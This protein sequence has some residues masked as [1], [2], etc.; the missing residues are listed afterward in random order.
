[1]PDEPTQLQMGYVSERSLS[2]KRLGFDPSNMRLDV[3]AS[4]GLEEI[5]VGQETTSTGVV[6]FD[7]GGRT[8]GYPLHIVFCIDK[9][10]SMNNGLE[11]SGLTGIANQILGGGSDTTKMDV[12]KEGL[13]KAL[14][15]LSSNDTFAVVGFNSNATEVVNPANGND[16][17]LAKSNIGSLSASNGTNISGG[18][19]R[20]RR[21]LQGMP[22]EEAVELIVLISDGKGRTPSDRQLQQMYSDAGITIQAAGVGNDYDREELLSVSQQ[23]QGELEHIDSA[24]GLKQFFA[25]EVSNARN[26]VALDA[27]LELKPSTMITI[28]EVYY[29]YAEQTSTV[30]PEWRGRAVALDLGD[31][32]HENPP[33]VTLEMDV[34][35][36]QSDAELEAPLVTAMLQTNED[37][38]SDEMT[39][40]VDPGI[41]IEK[42]DEDGESSAPAPSPEFILKKVSTLA[43]KGQTSK[44]RRY[45]EE[46]EDNLSPAKYSE[47]KS[48]ID[49]DDLSGLSKL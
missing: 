27:E 13:K 4:T 49:D 17:S 43:Q 44:A 42:V 23:T 28:N 8:R 33:E 15:Q 41:G 47:A 12:A 2:F 34:A 1:M 46:H 6:N 36:E 35:P 48:L 39:V 25:G 9:S 20:S 26:V 5:V 24:R 30:E 40:T 7:I 38:D 37:S 18:L 31:V 16:T 45:L 29:S 19:E 32:N 10:G 21:L 14:G 22:R 11:S 3:T